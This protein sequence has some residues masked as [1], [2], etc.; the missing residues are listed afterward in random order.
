MPRAKT[1]PATRRTTTNNGQAR[2]ASA[3]A[4]EHVS[5]LPIHVAKPGDVPIGVILN[6]FEC[7]D[8]HRVNRLIHE[9]L[10]VF[11]AVNIGIPFEENQYNW[12]ICIQRQVGRQNADVLFGRHDGSAGIWI[13]PRQAMS[14]VTPGCYEYVAI[15]VCASC[16]ESR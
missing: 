11:L 4:S 14:E 16:G 9:G 12:R 1:K 6:E 10:A 13:I 5:S 3:D 7:V 15:D 2:R 8:W